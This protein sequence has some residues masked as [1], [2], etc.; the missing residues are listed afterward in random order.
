MCGKTNL[1]R[2]IE[3]YQFQV[4]RYHTWMNYYSLFHG[5]LLVAFY[6]LLEK[7]REVGSSICQWFPFLIAMLGFIIGIC[8]CYTVIGNKTWINNWLFVVRKME[9]DDGIYNLI[10]PNCCKSGFISTQKVM[11][12]FTIC[13]TVAWGVVACFCYPCVEKCKIICIVVALTVVAILLG[14][15]KNPLIHSNT[16]GM[17]NN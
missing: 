6:S 10:S 11:L 2:A 13:V 3:A 14:I 17:K 7:Y 12:L 4:N 15:I 9:G 1:D 5:A 16:K 8:W